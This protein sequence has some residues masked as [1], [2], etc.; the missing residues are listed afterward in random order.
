[1]I[2]TILAIVFLL[3]IVVAAFVGYKTVMQRGTSPEEMNLEKCSI[4]REKFE[5][6][7]LILRQIGDYK[8]L[9][10]CR[11]CV[12]SLYGDLGIKN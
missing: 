12:L 9:Y 6:S 4:C 1:M 7:Q 10:F 3:L 2:V 5:K 8:L 11:K